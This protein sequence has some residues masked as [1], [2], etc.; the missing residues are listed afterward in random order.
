[1]REPNTEPTINAILARPA[2]SMSPHHVFEMKEHLR[3][4]ASAIAE[5]QLYDDIA[6]AMLRD[7]HSAHDLLMR[8]GE[9]YPDSNYAF[10]KVRVALMEACVVRMKKV[11]ATWDKPEPISD[12]DLLDRAREDS[13]RQEPGR[14]LPG[15]TASDVA[16]LRAPEFGV[17]RYRD[18]EHVW[19]YAALT[20]RDAKIRDLNSFLVFR[21]EFG[22]ILVGPA[23]LARAIDMPDDCIFVAVDPGLDVPVTDGGA[24]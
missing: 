2:A 9:E 23:G 3:L 16:L 12:E 1:M 4:A 22:G 6:C 24:A 19:I 7:P 20:Q 5:A 17:V 8:Q 11:E 15:A 18:R 14:W 10:P 13:F 21:P